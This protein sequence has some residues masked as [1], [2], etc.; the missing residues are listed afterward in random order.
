MAQ[1][2]V[3]PVVRRFTLAS[4][5]GPMLDGVLAEAVAPLCVFDRDLSEGGWES[6]A[7]ESLLRR[8]LQRNGEDSLR[9]VLRNGWRGMRRG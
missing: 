8:F 2:E 4:E 7:R 9:I 6:P 3:F 1:A 5:M